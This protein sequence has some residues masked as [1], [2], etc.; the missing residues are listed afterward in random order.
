MPAE[1]VDTEP[2]RVPVRIRLRRSLTRG[3]K[4]VTND[5][6]DLF[7]PPPPRPSAGEATYRVLFVC[8][9]NVCRSPMA[10]GI[11]RSKLAAR[12]LLGKVVVDSAGTHGMVGRAAD[13]RARTCLRRYGVNIRDVRARRVIPQDLAYFDLIYVMDPQNEHD[14]KRLARN[15]GERRRIRRLSASSSPEGIPDPILGTLADF[16]AVY[17]TLDAECEQLVDEI[18]RAVNPAIS[19]RADD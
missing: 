19:V 7:A 18:R 10:E 2:R 13:W 15:D 6:F 5:G 17:S 8:R 3:V 4:R 14:L 11:L 16:E 12:G 9:G 1:R